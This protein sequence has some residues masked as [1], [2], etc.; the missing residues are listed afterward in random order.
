[1]TLDLTVITN[2]MLKTF[3]IALQKNDWPQQLSSQ[4]SMMSSNH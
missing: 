4:N 1:M 3:N 2:V